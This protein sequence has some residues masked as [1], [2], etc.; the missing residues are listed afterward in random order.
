MKNIHSKAKHLLKRDQHEK[1]VEFKIA[2]QYTD[3]YA[4]VYNLIGMEYL[5]MDNLN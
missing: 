3:D 5:F 2:L 1:V 4:D